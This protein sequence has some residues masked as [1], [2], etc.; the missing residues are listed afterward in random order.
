MPEEQARSIVDNIF[1]TLLGEAHIVDKPLHPVDNR[2]D[3]SK[4]GGGGAGAAVAEA[5]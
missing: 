2:P 3:T 1:H 4:G 5:E